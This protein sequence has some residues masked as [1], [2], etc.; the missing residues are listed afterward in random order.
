MAQGASI[1][2]S[3]RHDIEDHLRTLGEI[4]EI[5]GAMKNLAVMEIHKLTRLLSAQQRVVTS[6]EDGGQRFSRLP[7]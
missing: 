2:V 1:P 5:M 4:S 7:S 6:M 3:K